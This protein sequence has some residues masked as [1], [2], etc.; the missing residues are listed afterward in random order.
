MTPLVQ[1]LR[2]LGQQLQPH[3]EA[4]GI[5]ENPLALEALH[6]LS[7]PRERVATVDHGEGDAGGAL[8]WVVHPKVEE[9]AEERDR[10]LHA[11]ERFAVKGKYR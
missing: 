4:P 6:L 3:V 10:G 2:Q 9:V 8:V 7:G 5:H 1:L 11:H